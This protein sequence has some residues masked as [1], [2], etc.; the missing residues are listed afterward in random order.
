M[1]NIVLDNSQVEQI[2]H[3]LRICN[4]LLHNATETTRAAL[5][6]S[7]AVCVLDAPADIDRFI[8][9]LQ[10]SS[11]YLDARLA[12]ARRNNRP[13]NKGWGQIKPAQWGQMDLSFSAG[14][15]VPSPP[16][17]YERWRAFTARHLSR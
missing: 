8:N 7:L 3:Q 2:L 5:H 12:A 4:D 9:D 10:R 13:T 1:I 14:Q 15:A 16:G 6:S 17:P 11:R